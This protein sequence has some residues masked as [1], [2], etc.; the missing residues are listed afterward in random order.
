LKT[1]QK[2]NKVSEQTS[3]HSIEAKQSWSETSIQR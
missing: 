1:E 3:E 2:R